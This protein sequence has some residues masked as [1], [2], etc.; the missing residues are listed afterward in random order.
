MSNLN[1]LGAHTIHELEDTAAGPVGK[2]QELH[3]WLPVKS[4]YKV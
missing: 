3:M 4:S 2:C 1:P